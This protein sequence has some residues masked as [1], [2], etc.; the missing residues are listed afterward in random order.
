MTTVA[1]GLY[2]FGGMPVTAG[3]PPL[4]GANSHSYFVDPING[5][6]GNPGTSPNRAFATLYRAHYMMTAGQNDVCYLISDGTT[7]SSARLSLAVALS[8]QGPSETP[9]ATGTLTWSKNACHLVGITAP[10]GVNSRARIA[11]PTGTYASATFGSGNMVVVTA[12]GCYFANFGVTQAYST[13]GVTDIAWTDSG[14]RNTYSNVGFFGGQSAAAAAASGS[15]SL[16]VTGSTGENAFYTC[17]IGSDASV[18]R[19]GSF[20][21][22]VLAGGSP[23]N[24][25]YKCVIQTQAGSTSAAFWMTIGASGID[26]Y[27]LF[28][29]CVFVNM[30]VGSAAPFSLMAVGFSLD[31]APGGTVLLR[32]CISTGATKITTTGVAVTNQGAGNAG[33]GLGVAIT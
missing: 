20:A 9:A 32:N 2:Q 12:Q 16:L 5:A 23:R 7:A 11:T 21:E 26:R 8:A 4:L 30:R 10:G 31:A 33:G 14:G 1:D 15:A 27:V 24:R 22:L 29:D 25:F 19:T 6:D 18:A 13:G 3:M 28:D 17:T